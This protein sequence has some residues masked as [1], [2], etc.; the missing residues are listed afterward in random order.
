MRSLP[1]KHQTLLFS[2]T[3]PEEIEALA[4]VSDLAEIYIELQFLW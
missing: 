2:A 1:K 3:M 4:Q